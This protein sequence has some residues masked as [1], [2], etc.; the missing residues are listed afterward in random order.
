MA[1]APSALAWRLLADACEALGESPLAARHR[2][3]GLRHATAASLGETP[4]LRRLQGVL[5]R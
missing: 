3:E 2:D 4:G 5:E 1:L